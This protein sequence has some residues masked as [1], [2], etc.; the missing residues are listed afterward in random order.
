M[1]DR[2]Q[3][4]GNPVIEK[5][6][7]LENVA[8]VLVSKLGRAANAWVIEAPSFAGPFA[9]YKGFLSSITSSGEPNVYDPYGFPS[10]TSTTSILANCIQQVKEKI[11]HESQSKV[12]QDI[13]TSRIPT[14]KTYPQTVVLGFS[15]GGV[16]INQLLTELAHS[17]IHDKKLRN[18]SVE[19]HN[20]DF[21]HS[22][23]GKM[24]DISY[25]SK[26]EKLNMEGCER[27]HETNP[28]LPPTPQKFLES[29][30]EF[31]YVDVGLNSCGA[32]QTNPHVIEGIGRAAASRRTGLRILLHGTPR[33]WADRNR[34]WIAS[35][36]NKLLELLQDETRKHK[37]NKLQISEQLYFADRS[38]SLQM[39]FEII[40]NL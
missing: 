6:S 17:K 28:L 8:S 32:Y 38:P 39:H 34:P 23:R 22:L 29:I 25:I 14:E 10:A 3:G 33:Q 5:L 11:S 21:Q 36:K 18:Q 27:Q 20:L 7:D 24:I 35:E 9:V 12:S 37:E 40:E 1:G 15:K 26:Q 2:A 4:T 19:D 16:V 30:G 31:H 13:Q